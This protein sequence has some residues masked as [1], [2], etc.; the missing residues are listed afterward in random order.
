MGK[1]LSIKDTETYEL[2]AE[3]A[4]KTGLSMTQ[5]VKRAAETQLRILESERLAALKSWVESVEAI[6]LPEDI[7][8]ERDATPYQTRNLLP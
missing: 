3:I 2:V 1:A 6:E 7:K 5:S 4:A 8:F